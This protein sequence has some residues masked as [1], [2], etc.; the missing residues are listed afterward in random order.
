MLLLITEIP[1]FT[2]F[3]TSLVVQDFLHPPVCPPL[4]SH[5]LIQ[6]DPVG[7]FSYFIKIHHQLSRHKLP[8]QTMHFYIRLSFIREFPHDYHTP[9]KFNSVSLKIGLPPKRKGSTS[10]CHF[11]RG[12]VMLNFGGVTYLHSLIPPKK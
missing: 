2:V 9:W 7:C 3:Y 8:T 4:R 5:H 12:D 6:S 1:V 10:N 11:S